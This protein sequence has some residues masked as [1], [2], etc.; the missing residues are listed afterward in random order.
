M[1]YGTIKSTASVLQKRMKQKTRHVRSKKFLRKNKKYVQIDDIIK[2]L[3]EIKKHCSDRKG[4]SHLGDGNLFVS[5]VDQD[6]TLENIK[7]VSFDSACWQVA[8]FT[9]KSNCI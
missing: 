3:Q 4:E 2:A 9:R 6:G 1:D 5:M 8:L 7:Q